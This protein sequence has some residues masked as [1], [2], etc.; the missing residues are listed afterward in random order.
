MLLT[1]E[2]FIKITAMAFIDSIDPCFFIFYTG[3]LTAIYMSNIRRLLKAAIAFIAPVFLGYTAFILG[4]RAIVSSFGIVNKAI[5]ALIAVLLGLA[6]VVESCIKMRARRDQQYICKESD[7]S[8]AIINKLR[9]NKFIDMVANSERGLL[10]LAFLGLL[11]SFTLLPCTAGMAILFAMFYSGLP[12]LAFIFIALWYSLI[13]ISP[14]V[15]I[16]LG[17]LGVAKVKRF[18]DFLMERQEELRLAGGIVAILV[19]VYMYFG[20]AP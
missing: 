11:A 6:L 7:V 17:F 9:L 10:L 20:L 15:I 14:L 12:Y 4:L 19:G 18:R 3:I 8:C 2:D 13:F 16:T 1:P 5:I